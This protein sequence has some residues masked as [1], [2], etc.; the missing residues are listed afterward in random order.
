MTMWGGVGWLV[1]WLVG[2]GL[3]Y[4]GS[5]RLIAHDSTLS[6]QTVPLLEQR[7]RA[8]EAS[9]VLSPHEIYV[10]NKTGSVELVFEA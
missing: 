6:P 4:L 10:V 8:V 1:G 5:R 9:N 3:K 7:N 2:C